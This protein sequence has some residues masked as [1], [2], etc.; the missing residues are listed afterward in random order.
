MSRDTKLFE[1]TAPSTYCVRPAY[2]KEPADAEA[3]F[4]AARERIR[5]FKSGHV[6][7]VEADD[8]ERDEDSESDV[9][10]DPETDDLGA[11]TDTKK[12]GPN[13]VDFNANTVMIS[14]KDSGEVFQ[15]L[16]GCHGHEKVNEGLASIVAEGINAHKGVSA[17]SEIALCS[18]DVTNPN[19]EGIDIDKS[20]P[21]E[22]WVQ[23]LMEG[24]YS[25]LSVEERLN[26]LV[27]LISVAIEGNSIRVIIEVF[28]FNFIS[29]CCGYP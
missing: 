17:S 21:A 29:Y 26:A 27:A 19:L 3:I 7:A 23:G 20:I 1:R 16:D 13:T 15:T 28:S 22:P 10:E 12:E 2:R 18:N 25:D 14:G 6:D 5:E 8:G 9:A 24:E 4:S 11:E